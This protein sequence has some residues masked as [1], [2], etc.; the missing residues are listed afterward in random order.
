MCRQLLGGGAVLAVASPAL[1][2]Y[3]QTITAAAGQSMLTG[4][5]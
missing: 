4:F 1:A 5:T 2:A 3:G